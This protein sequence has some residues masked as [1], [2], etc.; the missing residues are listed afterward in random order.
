ML[1]RD[2]HECC[3]GLCVGILQLRPWVMGGAKIDPAATVDDS[4]VEIQQ[5]GGNSNG[6]CPSSRTV[7]A[8][9]LLRANA[10]PDGD[11]ARVELE[12]RTDN[13]HK[14]GRAGEVLWELQLHQHLSWQAKLVSIP[15]AV[16]GIGGQMWWCCQGSR[17]R[18]LWPAVK[19]VAAPAGVDHLPI[20]GILQSSGIHIIRSRHTTE[21]EEAVWRLRLQ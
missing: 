19:G 4:G 10:A 6:S 1:P 11:V 8:G 16:E 2:T 20:I 3:A 5:Q 12:S 17:L 7:A 21:E 15:A 13:P 14:R 9:K 18:W